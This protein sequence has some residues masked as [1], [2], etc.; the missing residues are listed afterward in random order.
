MKGKIRKCPHCKSKSG[1]E[2]QYS[3]HGTGS[4]TRD[5]KGNVY[6]SSREIFDK[7]DNV[8]QCIDCKKYFDT[9]KVIT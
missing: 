6:K 5:F 1:F 8:V 9:D 4:E 7:T 2:M 3:I